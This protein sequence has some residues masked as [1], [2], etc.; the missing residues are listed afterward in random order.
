MVVVLILAIILSIAVPQ[1]L[2]AR[3]LSQ[4]KVCVSQLS[5]IDMAKE[6]FATEARLAPGAPVTV[7]DLWPEYI[8]GTTFPRCPGGGEYALQDVGVDPTCTL[9]SLARV[10]HN[11]R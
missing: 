9:A 1:F 3:G 10:P 8:K 6:M 4:Q 7:P 5:A 2:T 11:I